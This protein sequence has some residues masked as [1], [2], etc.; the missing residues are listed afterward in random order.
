MSRHVIIPEFVSLFLFLSLSLPFL[1]HRPV[2]DFDDL[3]QERSGA[4]SG[5]EYLHERLIRANALGNFHTVVSLHHLAP[6]CAISE[7]IL[8]TELASQ[9][10]I[11]TAHN[12][13][14]DGDWRVEDAALHAL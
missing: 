4:G 11:D 14:D 3:N 1:D 9:N 2:N 5:I 13:L 8:K 12:K 7:T 10:L 6:G